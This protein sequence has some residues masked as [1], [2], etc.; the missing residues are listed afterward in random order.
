VLLLCGSRWSGLKHEEFPQPG[1]I[2]RGSA[3]PRQCAQARRRTPTR[4]PSTQI[5]PPPV[6]SFVPVQI[7]QPLAGSM[8]R[9]LRRRS[10]SFS[11]LVCLG[12]MDF[13]SE[14]VDMSAEDRFAKIPSDGKGRW[15]CIKVGSVDLS[16]FGIKEPQRRSVHKKRP[17]RRRPAGRFELQSA[18]ISEQY[19]PTST[20]AA[21]LL[22]QNGAIGKQATRLLRSSGCGQLP[23]AGYCP[24]CE[25]PLHLQSTARF[26][27]W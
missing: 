18:R 17:A 11:I 19:T 8:R 13:A 2:A 12:S 15:E 26:H 21:F 3:V 20:A 23:V 27:G 25:S 7:Q 1:D 5:T 10:F 4:T 14:V 24:T 9:F 16:R 6:R 22:L